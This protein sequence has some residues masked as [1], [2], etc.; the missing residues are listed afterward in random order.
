ML[1]TFKP[2]SV[3]EAAEHT[4]LSQLT[5]RRYIDRGK[6]RRY[7]IG[8]RRIGLDPADVEALIQPVPA[9]TA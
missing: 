1:T 7:R 9:R 8:E 5:I 3:A 2:M 6:L 4:G